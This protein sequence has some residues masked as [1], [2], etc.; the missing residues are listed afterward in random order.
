MAEKRKFESSLLLLGLGALLAQ[1]HA[2]R[3]G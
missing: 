1:A 3:A 2:G